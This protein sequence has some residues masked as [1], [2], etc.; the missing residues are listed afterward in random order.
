VR[1]FTHS[2]RS[3]LRLSVVFVRLL[4]EGRKLPPH[5]REEVSSIIS[6]DP[7]RFIEIIP[8]N[9][10]ILHLANVDLCTWNPTFIS[11]RA[12][13]WNLIDQ[14]AKYFADRLSVCL[15]ELGYTSDTPPVGRVVEYWTTTAEIQ[16]FNITKLPEHMQPNIF[17]DLGP[18]PV[19]WQAAHTVL[20]VISQTRELATLGAFIAKVPPGCCWEWVE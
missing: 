16:A 4:R 1:S 12:G 10:G 3:G 18:A 9:S 8:A 5:F 13:R 6:A 17:K 15:A 20:D 14:P 19:K 11:T 2:V 7:Q